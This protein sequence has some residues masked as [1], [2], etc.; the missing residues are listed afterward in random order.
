MTEQTS[1][2]CAALPLAEYQTY[3]PKVLVL[4]LTAAL[5]VL[6]MS[7]KEH[8]LRRKIKLIRQGIRIIQQT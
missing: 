3:E 1:T 2:N 8:G 5:L 6:V 7:I 4:T